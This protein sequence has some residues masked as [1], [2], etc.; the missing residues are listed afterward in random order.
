MMGM[1]TLRCPTCVTLLPDPDAR[2]CPACHTKLRKRRRRPIVLGESNRLSGRSLPVDVELRVRAETRYE[3]FESFATKQKKGKEEPVEAV[4]AFAPSQ[5]AIAEPEPEHAPVTAASAAPDLD[6]VAAE[7]EPE[8]APEAIVDLEPEI[9]PEPVVLE[10]IDPEPEPVEVPEPAPPILTMAPPLAAAPIGAIAFAA[11]T[12]APEPVELDLP[13]PEP[14]QGSLV[15]DELPV[16]PALTVP[17]PAPVA[18]DVLEPARREPVVAGEVIDL[19]GDPEPAGNDLPPTVKPDAVR[20]RR[21]ASRWQ[22]VPS[23]GMSSPF[24]GTLNDMVEE[25]HRKARED[26]G[27]TRPS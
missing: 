10:E 13:E 3:S 1:E 25:L 7:S 16:M 15:A 22:A 19:T 27:N 11:E 21:R 12:P 24:D 6:L 20:P 23:K 9:E 14:I 5:P 18:V 2:R 4:L 26:A 8:P 17:E